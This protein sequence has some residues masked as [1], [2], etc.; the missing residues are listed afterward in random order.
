MSQEK[1][2][3]QSGTSTIRDEV[4]EPYFIGKDHYCYTVYENVTS[5]ESPNKTYVKSWGHFGKLDAALKSVAQMKVHKKK[6]FN[7]L[8]EYIKE[9]TDIQEEFNQK[10]SITI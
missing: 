6:D 5:S 9:W 7:S 10:L 3:A 1:Q 4:L 2:E 8:Q